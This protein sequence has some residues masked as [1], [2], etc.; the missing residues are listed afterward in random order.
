[1]QFLLPLIGKYIFLV[2]FLSLL[3][4]PMAALF[5]RT[6]GTGIADAGS[7]LTS[8]VWA[9]EV[10]SKTTLPVQPTAA[11]APTTTAA[12][13]TAATISTAPTGTNKPRS[14]FFDLLH[15]ELSQ[16]LVDAA[17][18][19][20]SF[21]AD[22]SYVKEENHSYVKVRYDIFKE[23]RAKMTFD[24]AFDLRLALP[25]L[26]R[27][28][29]LVFSSEPAQPVNNVNAPVQTASERFGQTDQRTLT[30]AIH[31]FFRDTEQESFFLRTGIQ[32]SRL[33]PVIVLEP[34][35]RVLFP[36]T[37][38]NIRFTQDVLW[39]SDTS[40]QTDTRFD[41]ERLLP[42]SLFFRT[43]LDGL[44][45]A[46]VKG[47]VYSL[48]YLLRQP[49]A[50]TYALDYEWINTYQTRPEGELTEI[51]FRVRYR[52]SF[53]REWL[54]FEISPQARLPRTSNFHLLPGI[55]FRLEMFFGG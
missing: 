43:S 7:C 14:G 49:L 51:D 48:S 24:P 35:Y 39:R 44:W 32:F 8:T 17:A 19:M 37:N 36:Y 9:D 34:R 3:C 2:G 54:F 50:P 28:T 6:T 13:T 42:S 45:A 10:D 40:W 31:Y 46:Q 4:Q 29:H 25:E 55:L 16:Q 21:F 15:G 27:K 20:D 1:M 12:L 47:Y 22:T 18:W 53:W 5:F 33:S 11:T 30:T 52:H 41:F 23:E 26:E 38:W